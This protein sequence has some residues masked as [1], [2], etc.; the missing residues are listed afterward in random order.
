MYPTGRFVKIN[1]FINREEAKIRMREMMTQDVTFSPQQRL[2]RIW[3]MLRMS[4]TD[5][6][7]MAIKYCTNEYTSNL[8]PA[9]EEWEKATNL[10]VAREKQLFELENFEK[11]GSD[12][13][14]F[15]MRGFR[16]SSAA[17]L[18]EA[19][20][21]DNIYK[22]IDG[23][24]AKLEVILLNIQKRYKDTI[25]YNGR[26]YLEKMKW[27]RIEML[28]WLTEDRRIKYFKHEIR[29]KQLKVNMA[30]IR[31]SFA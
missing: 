18:G 12:P 24:Q 31:S 26:N 19:Q 17:R 25:S 3:N 4:E 1:F 30:E 10:I 16:G 23:L 28:H 29:A 8:L 5:K 13:N 15:F 11:L 21:R 27:D 2:E 20:H 6:L 14:R 9:I 7:D 22:I